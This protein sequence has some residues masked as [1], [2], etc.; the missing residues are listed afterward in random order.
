L[1]NLF[2]D[3]T[4]KAQVDNGVLRA[5]SIGVSNAEL[6]TINGVETIVKCELQEVSLVDI[7]ANAN[8]V[9]LRNKKILKFTCYTEGKANNNNQEN[10]GILS[11]IKTFLGLE[12]G[13]TDEDVLKALEALKNAIQEQHPESVQAAHK[14]NLITN[15]DLKNYSYMDKVGKK[16][17]Q[18]L[19]S[20]LIN[21]EK[22][23]V[24]KEVE[25]G[26]ADRKFIYAERII[27]QELG[28]AIGLEKLKKILN[29]MAGAVRC[30][31]IISSANS[32]K[33]NW[34]LTEYRKFAADEL[35]DN[36]ELYR[37]LLE[38]ENQPTGKS[39]EW[40]RKNDPDYLKKNPKEYKRLLEESK[41]KQ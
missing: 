19:C 31:D 25:K 7:P 29:C 2:R 3:G 36:P 13:C 21:T 10:T 17:F 4:V 1:V 38:K 5:V 27:F 8:A 20:R 24:R 34:G 22:E 16:T 12:E 40:Y 35:N 9:K 15:S 14:L 11:Q 6:K 28:D 32:N 37:Y 30:T 18:S 33:S 23:N 41:N 39:L 26:L